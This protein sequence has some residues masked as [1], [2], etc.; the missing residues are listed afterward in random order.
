MCR[1]F[2]LFI[3]PAL[4]FL[5]AQSYT[6]AFDTLT[7]LKNGKVLRHATAGGLNSSLFYD[8]DLNEDGKKDFVIFE[9]GGANKFGVFKCFINKGTVAQPDYRYDYR[10]SRSFPLVQNWAVMIDFNADGKTDLFAHTNS[11]IRAYRNLGF[12]NGE[13]QWKLEKVILSAIYT[14]P[15]GTFLSSIYASS[16]GYPAIYDL[17]SDGDHDILSFGPTGNFLDAFKNISKETY[18][19][20]DSLIF[21]H[22]NFCWANFS[23]FN[24]GVTM[25]ACRSSVGRYEELSKERHAGA[26]LLAYDHEGNNTPDLL[27]HDIGCKSTIFLRNGG[28]PSSPLITDTTIMF[29]N[30]PNKNSTRTARMDGSGC[31]SSL[32]DIDDDGKK[33]LIITPSMGEFE[34]AWS[35]W[36]YSNTS[37]TPTVNWVF[38][39]SAFIQSEMADAGFMSRPVLIDIDSDGK[40]DLLLG[41]YGTY[42]VTCRV[43][44]IHYYKNIGTVTV[45]SFSFMTDNFLNLRQVFTSTVNMSMIICPGDIDSD[46]DMDLIISQGGRTIHWYENSGGAGNPCNFSQLHLNPF[47]INSSFSMDYQ[48]FVFDYDNDNKPDIIMGLTNGK[49]QFYKNTTSGSNPSF[50][51]ISGAFPGLEAKGDFFMYGNNGFSCP[52]LWRENNQIYMLAGNTTGR[53]YL[54]QMP[55]SVNGN[56]VLLDSTYAYFYAGTY[57]TPWFEDINGDGKRDLFS[58]NAGGGITFF[59][60][61]S[62]FVGLTEHKTNNLRLYPNPACDEII[63]EM[64]EPV[65]EIRVF[66][67]TGKKYNLEY[68][69]YNL[70]TLVHV[71]HLSDGFYI[72]EIRTISGLMQKTCIINR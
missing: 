26:A 57:S 42:S 44:S 48:P 46:G 1:Y 62:P 68:D 10:L 17:D 23:E 29:P 39:D 28:T 30:Y 70:K 49:F 32:A 22:W 27:L 9:L 4:H 2:F 20:T 52:Y 64:N 18:N 24:C 13:I 16:Y 43:P 15:T 25:N 59:S 38:K 6:V 63:I 58:G 60:S 33:E 72:F 34:N 40:K 53:I 37:T 5:I 61:Q 66:D 36:S 31:R 41:S 45:P 56:A 69:I 47:G 21:Q 55:S 51:L 67:L 3:V 7:F 8:G 11:G 71:G 65:E 19:H 50:S 12:N 14:T 35:V 54:Y